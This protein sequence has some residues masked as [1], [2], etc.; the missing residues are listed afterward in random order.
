[1]RA[2]QVFGWVLIVVGI[3]LIPVGVYLVTYHY[4]INFSSELLRSGISL[5]MSAVYPYS[6]V[7]I[8]VFALI[9]VLL[10]DGVLHLKILAKSKQN[11]SVDRLNS[12]I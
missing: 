10:V 5:S 7:G 9:L 6:L 12:A 3:L 8:G 1:M 4:T 2:K 11:G